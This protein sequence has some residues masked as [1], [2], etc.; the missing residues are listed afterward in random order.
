MIELVKHCCEHLN[1]IVHVFSI[2]FETFITL[3]ENGW[4]LFIKIYFL[5]DINRIAFGELLIYPAQYN[6]IGTVHLS[7]DG[8]R[9]NIDDHCIDSPTALRKNLTY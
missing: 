8:R 5:Q 6:T 2:L 1:R 3:K 9:F 4:Y 7:G